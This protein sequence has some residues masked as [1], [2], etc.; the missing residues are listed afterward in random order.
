[1]AKVKGKS[2]ENGFTLMEL[3]ITMVIMLIVLG[4]LSGIISGVQIEYKRQRIQ[5]EAVTSAQTAQDNISRI[6]RMAGTKG[7]QCSSAFQPQALTPGSQSADGSYASLAIEAD[8]N[9]ADCQL[10]GI[11]ENVTISVQAGNLY[12]DA[13]RQDPFVDK[14]NA[15]RFR[16]YDAANQLITDAV[17]NKQKIRYVRIEVDAQTSSSTVTTIRTGVQVRAG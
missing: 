2:G 16:F 5:M 13:A 4:I 15:I 7:I 14:I 1:M 17:T 6:I 12:L 11:D 9:P 10:T 8:W 3:M